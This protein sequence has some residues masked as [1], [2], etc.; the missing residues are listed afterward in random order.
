MSAGKPPDP[1][2]TAA[3]EARGAAGRARRRHTS[4]GEPDSPGRRLRDRGVARRLA[5]PMTAETVRD[6]LPALRPERRGV[7]LHGAL[8]GGPAR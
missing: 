4:P 7:L 1:P 5:S 3:A 6:A 8:G 2:G